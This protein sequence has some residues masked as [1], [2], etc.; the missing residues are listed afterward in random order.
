MKSSNVISHTEEG[1]EL[2]DLT[3]LPDSDKESQCDSGLESTIWN[4]STDDCD[5][6]SRDL[7][8]HS[9]NLFS[10]DL[11]SD[12][13]STFCGDVRITESAGKKDNSNS[14][15]LIDT[16]MVDSVPELHDADS[17]SFTTTPI[18]TDE[19]GPIGQVIITKVQGK[20]F[21]DLTELP[22]SD[23][24]SHSSNDEIWI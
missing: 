9:D 21:I 10:V 24:E 19:D 23:A 7:R 8:D 5:L 14:T 16:V 2:I 11:F 6:S 4:S 3:G 22:D 15:P 17:K 18:D 1:N 12:D 20:D 13:F